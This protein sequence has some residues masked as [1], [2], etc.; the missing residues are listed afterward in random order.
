VGRVLVCNPFVS[1]PICELHRIPDALAVLRRTDLGRGARTPLRPGR[2]PR[3]SAPL[4][5]SRSP[6]IPSRRSSCEGLG[7][8][9]RQRSSK[10]PYFHVPLMTA[11]QS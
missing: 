2:S 8:R 9:S 11:L 5:K 10:S 7:I 6:P 1:G 4:E 3:R